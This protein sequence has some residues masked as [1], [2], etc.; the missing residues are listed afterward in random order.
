MKHF[1]RVFTWM[2]FMDVLFLSSV[3]N[4]VHSVQIFHSI[5]TLLLLLVDLLLIVAKDLNSKYLFIH[6]LNLL[7]FNVCLC[8]FFP[9]IVWPAKK[10]FG[11]F[12]TFLIAIDEHLNNLN[13]TIILNY[14]FFVLFCLLI[15]QWMRNELLRKGL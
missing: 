8:V 9:F 5:L 4:S 11:I 6:F 13:N 12:F 3:R 2:R 1:N 15:Y 7:L 10:R 14:F